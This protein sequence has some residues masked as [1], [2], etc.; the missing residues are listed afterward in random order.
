MRGRLTNE[1]RTQLATMTAERDVLQTSMNELRK[2]CAEIIG[3]DEQTWPGHGNVPLAIAACLAL[4]DA[5]LRKTTAERDAALAKVAVLWG[6]VDDL[7]D[8]TEEVIRISD[9]KHDSW[10]AAKASIKRAYTALEETK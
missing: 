3:A 10:D 6:V 2:T 8:K 5:E 7:T 9:R 1:L 4:R